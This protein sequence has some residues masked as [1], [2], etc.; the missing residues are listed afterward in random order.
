MDNLAEDVGASVRLSR[1][2]NFDGFLGPDD[3]FG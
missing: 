1:S 2:R 3:H